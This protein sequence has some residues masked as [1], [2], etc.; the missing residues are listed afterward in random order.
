MNT[1]CRD[2]DVQHVKKL[3]DELDAHPEQGDPNVAWD[4]HNATDPGTPLNVAIAHDR[5]IIAVLLAKHPRVDVNVPNEY[6]VAPL[7]NAV[8]MS[9]DR[10]RRLPDGQ[11]VP[12]VLEVV[13]ALI[14]AGAQ[15]LKPMELAYELPM[16]LGHTLGLADRSCQDGG[17]STPAV[18]DLLIER[19][20]LNPTPNVLRRLLTITV[21]RTLSLFGDDGLNLAV[22][23][24]AA[25]L[26]WLLDRHAPVD[27]V[28]P[29]TGR[30]IMDVAKKWQDRAPESFALLERATLRME[31]SVEADEHAL[32][33]TT[34]VRSR[35]RL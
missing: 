5:S 24:I 31:T 29:T 32:N 2:G 21:S 33:G 27:H 26:Q 8:A 17:S 12:G 34:P 6:G 28:D 4:A 35:P 13:T 23:P 9:E 1:A 30:G 11:P 7:L 19:G 18:L 20:W 10:N 3:L 14:E 16:G 25:T 15:P 22:P